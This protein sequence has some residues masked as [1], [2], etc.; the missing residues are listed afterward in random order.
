MP[1]DPEVRVGGNEIYVRRL[2]VDWQIFQTTFKWFVRFHSV[3]ENSGKSPRGY[4]KRHNSSRERFWTAQASSCTALSFSLPGEFLLLISL[5]TLSTYVQSLGAQSKDRET[6]WSENRP[7]QPGLLPQPGR[8][9]LPDSLY[10]LLPCCLTDSDLSPLILLCLIGHQGPS[11]T[12]ANMSPQLFMQA[13]LPP[14]SDFNL[15]L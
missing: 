9:S 15:T 13:V 4:L 8:Y 6:R 7:D 12:T 14:S 3:L 2:S 5:L 10:C 1:R 11:W